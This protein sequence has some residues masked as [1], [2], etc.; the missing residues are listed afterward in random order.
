MILIGL[1]LMS[2]GAYLIHHEQVLN[3]L[4]D[5]QTITAKGTVQLSQGCLNL[6]WPYLTGF[7]SL[8]VGTVTTLT[9]LIMGN[10]RGQ[11]RRDFRQAMREG[12][13]EHRPSAEEPL[14]H[15][16]KGARETEEKM[17]STATSL[18]WDEKFATPA[19]Q[20]HPSATAPLEGGDDLG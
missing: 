10:N 4:C 17:R 14:G 16:R 3:S 15:L 7:A 19:H 9:A 18:S 1:G 12:R 8:I 2:Y 5:A 6:T 13:F 20:P 11:V